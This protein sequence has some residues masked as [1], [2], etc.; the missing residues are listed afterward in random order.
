[1]RRRTIWIT[2]I[3][4]LL[5][6]GAAAAWMWQKPHRKAE[7]EK[8]IVVTA[9]RL[10]QEYETDAAAA[11]GRYLDKVVA[12]SGTIASVEIN[13]AGQSTAVFESEDPLN[14]VVCTMREKASK[15]QTGMTITLQGICTG[16]PS[17]VTITECVEVD[18][19]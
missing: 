4:V 16:K 1:M 11:D 13:Q 7:D 8:A 5:L 3:A 6:A 2:I 15:L 17:D 14:S 18:A 9:A 12:V 19:N 10:I